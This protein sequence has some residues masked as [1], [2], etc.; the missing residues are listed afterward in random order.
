LA[1]LEAW[2]FDSGDTSNRRGCSAKVLQS[3]RLPTD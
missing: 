1:R 3:L 2:S